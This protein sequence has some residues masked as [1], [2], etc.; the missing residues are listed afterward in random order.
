MM[1]KLTPVILLI[2]LTSCGASNNAADRSDGNRR[3]QNA[4]LVKM[5]LSSDAFED[6]RPIPTEY[7]C[8]GTNQS[9]PLRWGDPPGGTKSFALVVDDPDAPSGTFRHW[10]AFDIPAGTRFLA[11]AQALGTQA[12]NDKGTVGYTGPCPPEGNGA[13]HYHFKLFALGVATLGL[14]AEA[15]VAEVESAAIRHALG[16]GELIGTYERR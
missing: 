11:K 6:G 4:T 12:T 13:H 10:A 8:D 16:K 15:K 5:G 9:P 14:S 7:S 1:A 2:A 3:V